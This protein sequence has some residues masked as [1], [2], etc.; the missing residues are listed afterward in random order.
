MRK[1][2]AFSGLAAALAFCVWRELS[3]AFIGGPHAPVS[4]MALAGGVFTL[5]I[6][7]FI[8]D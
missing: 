5:A 6:A 2:I 8:R 7:V 3:Y 4:A 1:G